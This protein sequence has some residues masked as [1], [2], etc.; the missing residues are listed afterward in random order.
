M[1]KDNQQ[2][3]RVLIG[4]ILIDDLSWD[5]ALE[6]VADLIRRRSGGYVVTPN[7]DH[8]V[9]A[10][11]DPELREIYRQA[12][13]VF[14]DGMPLLWAARFLGTPLRAKISGS[15]VL[16]RFC[17]RAAREGYR[18]FF[19]GGQE[20]AAEI[21]ARRLTRRYPGLKVEGIYSPPW[22]FEL[23]RQENTRVIEKINRVRPE[24]LF[25]GLGT[26]KQEKWISRNRHLYRAG[27]S[28]PVGAGFDFVSGKFPRAPYW[29]QQGGLE[30]FWRLL[31][32]PRRLSRRYLGRDL[33]FFP[34]IYRQKY[35]GRTRDEI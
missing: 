25:V 29:M 17:P 22:G 19:L 2:R 21:A 7:V 15:D 6:T 35:H 24:I 32:E 11:S 23:D 4:S 28:F 31:R 12:S 10:E 5:E 16:I 9:L 33:K 1:K 18:I 26:P 3:R 20:D 27:V 8:V 13:A 34:I 14:C 30:W